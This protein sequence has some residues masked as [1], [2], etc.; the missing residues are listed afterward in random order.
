MG[1]S[2]VTYGTRIGNATYIINELIHITMCG[3]RDTDE[4]ARASD[5]ARPLRLIVI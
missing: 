2:R 4:H 1:A 3:A 5:A